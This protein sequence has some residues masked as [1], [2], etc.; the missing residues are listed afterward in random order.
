VASGKSDYLHVEPFGRVLEYCIVD[1]CDP[2][3]TNI[4]PLMAR[5]PQYEARDAL[6]RK[7][8]GSLEGARNNSP[9]T[10]QTVAAECENLGVAFEVEHIPEGEGVVIYWIGDKS[11]DK[12]LVYFHGL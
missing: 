6:F 8:F 9:D 5:S 10:H 11:I 12:V 4:C 7:G 3:L 1:S 2:V